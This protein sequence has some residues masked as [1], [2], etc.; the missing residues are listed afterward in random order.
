MDRYPHF[1]GDWSS[2]ANQIVHRTLSVQPR[3][4]VLIWTDPT[5]LPELTEQVR[6]EVVRAGAVEVA[7]MLMISP[8][9]EQHRKV[10]RRREDPE[11]KR[12]EDE[13]LQRI[14]D[15]T[16]VFIWLPNRWAH[17]FLQS[18]EILSHWPG[19]GVHFHWVPGWWPWSL[20]DSLFDRLS[21]MYERALDI[22]YSALAER[23]QRA[24]DL[25]ANTRV[26][27]S[28]PQGTDL[29]F[30]LKDPHFHRND[31]IASKEAIAAKAKP[32]SARDREEELPA[33]VI[34]T[35]D[36]SEA[37]GV[38][39]IP[40]ETYPAWTGRFVGEMRF[41]FEDDR[42]KEFTTQYHQ[43]YVDAMW[44]LE[45][46]AKDRIGE[47]V[48]GFN[49]ELVPIPGHGDDGVVSYFGFGDGVV[50]ISMGYNIE[51][52]GANDSSFLHNWLYMTDATVTADGRTI[53]ENGRVVV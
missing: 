6:I 26:R 50:R 53:V 34:R 51:S 29:S 37:E 20:D 22:D 44:E 25:F 28:T 46:G 12:L 31:G 24:I 10:H 7:A 17:N 30:L 38:L 41:V 4:R 8:G 45:T 35:V 52:G 11:L 48:V 27:I 39:I 5:L 1:H 3:E 47:F 14:F 2:I 32:G 19:R 36:V 16:D 18:E 23:Q 43:R 13:P 33:G 42:I 21:A 49:P 15:E 9:L 40:N